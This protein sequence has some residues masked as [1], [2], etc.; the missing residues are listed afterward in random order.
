MDK[1]Q[2]DHEKK[3]KKME[4]EKRETGENRF[5]SNDDGKSSSNDRGHPIDISSEESSSGRS[6][7]DSFNAGGNDSDYDGGHPADVSSNGEGR[8]DSNQTN[9]NNQ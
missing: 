4:D 3:L 6:R 1:E 8:I 9:S 2:R 5:T 7:G